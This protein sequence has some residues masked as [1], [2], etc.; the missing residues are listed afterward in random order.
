MKK[1]FLNLATTMLLAGIIAI[2]CDS[3]ATKVETAKENVKIA[4]D[5]LLQTQIDAK[6]ELQIK[7][8]AEE[9]KNFKAETEVKIKDNETRIAELKVKLKKPG[10]VLDPIYADRIKTL[11]DKNEELRKRISDYE[12]SQSEWAKFK[13]E[14]NSDMD[15]L[16]KA[17]K[18]F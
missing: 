9:W 10:K 12:A 17:L 16:V 11:E 15:N 2:S 5:K 7:A 18:D 4:E 3:K 6:A 1:S 14:F 8:D 13:A